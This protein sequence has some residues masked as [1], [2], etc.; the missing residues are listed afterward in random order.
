[1][2]NKKV[3]KFFQKFIM[4]TLIANKKYFKNFGKFL[5]NHVINQKEINVIQTLI[6]IKILFILKMNVYQLYLK[7]YLSTNRQESPITFIQ[8][9]GT[10]YVK[11][12]K[13]RKQL[14]PLLKVITL[15]VLVS[16]TK[17]AGIQIITSNFIAIWMV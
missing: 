13:E 12:S 3:V 2:Q 9:I 17:Q 1:M 8:I 6:K 10:V 11:N 5:I 16:K 7:K 14:Y 4:L 15:M